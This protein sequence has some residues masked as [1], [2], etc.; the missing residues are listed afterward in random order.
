MSRI[1]ITMLVVTLQICVAFTLA[2]CSRSQDTE[3]AKA[4]AEATTLKAELA[5]A[6]AEA[7]ATKAR[8]EANAA[9]GP[10]DAKLIL[11]GWSGGWQ[12]GLFNKFDIW[13]HE[14][15]DPALGRCDIFGLIP[16]NQNWKI[17]DG[18]LFFQHT[19]PLRW[20]GYHYELTKDTLTY[21]DQKDNKAKFVRKKE[22]AQ[23]PPLKSQSRIDQDRFLGKWESR[24][25]LASK[26]E[27]LPEG[28]CIIAYGAP[29]EWAISEPGSMLVVTRP[30]GSPISTILKYTFEGDNRIQVEFGDSPSC[31]YQRA[32][33]K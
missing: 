29:G 18:K 13:F 1:R 21:W 16:V 9:K 30:K 17:T 6:K 15:T 27:F 26:M 12:D 31:I 19:D 5:R 22:G 3:L 24:G 7:D 4:K 11:G 32:S 33:A 20:Q 23:L 8:T 28:K 2:G 25:L 10:Q 14:T